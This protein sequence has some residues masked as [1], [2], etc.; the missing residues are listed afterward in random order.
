[1]GSNDIPPPHVPSAY[2][3]TC[4]V[5]LAIGGCLWTVTYVLM[6]RQSLRDRTYS[7]PLAALAFNFAWE[8]MFT[9][10]ISETS[11]EKSVFACWMVLDIGL[12]YTMVEYG[13]N[14]WRHAPVVGRH[15]GKILL[16]SVLWICWALW[17]FSS[18][19][20]DLAN[21]INPKDGKIF[22]GVVGPDTTELGYWTSVVAQVLLSAM[23][24]AQLIVRGH[25][26]GASYMIWMARFFGS[27]SGQVIY[28]GY[29][30]YVWSEAHGYFMSRFSVCLWMTWILADLAYLVVLKKVKGSEIILKDGRKIRGETEAL[31]HAAQMASSDNDDEELRQAIAMSLEESKPPAPSSTSNPSEPMPNSEA[32]FDEDMRRAIALSLEESVPEINST[33]LPNQNSKPTSSVLQ[34]WHG[35]DRKAMEQERLARLGKRKRSVS[36]G[37]PSKA[38]KQEVGSNS[39]LENPTE[40][41]AP[42]HPPIQYPRGVIKRTW[43]FKHKRTNDIKIEEVL[44][45]PTLNIAVLSAFDWDV[46]WIFSKL[47][48]VKVKQIWIMNAKGKDLQEQWR[49][50]AAEQSVPNLKMHFPP[51]A[52]PIQNMHSKLMLLFHDTHLRI[53]LPTANLNKFDWGETNLNVR[54]K[55][56]EQAA[57]MEN[58]VFLIDLPRFPDGK[59]GAR[60]DLTWFGKELLYYLEAQKL[61][62]TSKNAV[63]G[64]LKFDFSQTSHLAFIHSIGGRHASAGAHWT[65]LPGLSMSL[66]RLNLGE[67]SQIQLDYATSS[68]GALNLEFLKKLYISACGLPPFKDHNIP[69]DSILSQFRF[70]FP[71]QATVENSTGGVACGGTNTLNENHFSSSAFPVLSMRDYKSTKPGVL[72]HNKILLARGRRGKENTPFAWAYIGSANLTESAWGAQKLAKAQRKEGE[73]WGNTGMPLQRGDKLEVRNWECGILVPVLDDSLEDLKLG[74]SEVPPISVFEKTLEIPFQYPGETYI[75]ENNSQQKKPWFFRSQGNIAMVNRLEQA[76]KTPR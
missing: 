56:M 21:P 62:E 26:G 44:Q 33:P 20:V 64:V 75:G 72:S 39:T 60:E 50:D 30:Y 1:M 18:W 28:Y 24:L 52:S 49:R 14:E 32:S 10:Y 15:I 66:H 8:I 57:V 9:I 5:L 43:A 67:V 22:R 17:A 35:I 4:T 36:P 2:H 59:A 58:S 3:A 54:T 16:G 19:W 55:Q 70:Y 45:A 13:A 23:L 25:S 74:P 63:E 11:L 27:L 42:G 71:S 41:S 69:N 65:G 34:G 68:V 7:M 47:D 48:P 53:V 76:R 12:A 38:A 73:E 31:L 46:D 6:I 37:A 29:C 51:M 61:G 40:S